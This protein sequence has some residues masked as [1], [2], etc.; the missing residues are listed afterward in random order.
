MRRLQI[1]LRCVVVA[2]FVAGVATTAGSTPTM[3]AANT[4][5]GAPTSLT[6]NGR[7]APLG[8]GT[9][10]LSFGWFV[11]D[12]DRGEVQKAYQVLVGIRPDVAADA[13]PV[14]DS[15]TVSSDES[16]AVN[17]TGPAL[18]SAT[19]Y[20]WT[21]R[22]WD[23]DGVASTY[24]SPQPFETGLLS[25]SDW[26]AGWIQGANGN[27]Y[28]S[29]FDLTKPIA[30]ARL[31]AT[32]QGMYRTRINGAEVPGN[33]LEPMWTTWD[34]R[35][36]V[37]T[38][39]V[40]SM[41]VEGRNAIGMTLVSGH[42]GTTGYQDLPP[43]ARAQLI[44]T[45]SDGGTATIGT[46]PSWRTAAGP[47]VAYINS[48][49]GENYTQTLEKSGWDRV[50]FNDASWGAVTAP[51]SP[52]SATL[53]PTVAPPARV[54]ATLPGQSVTAVPDSRTPGAT[55]YVVDFGRNI[56][57]WTRLT[58]S[59][60]AG[61][62]MQIIYGEH[63]SSTGEVVNYRPQTDTFRFSQTGAITHTTQF[64]V[65][66]FR[67]AE[68]RGTVR[69]VP[70]A[71]TLVAEVVHDDVRSA[72]EFVSSDPMFTAIDDAQRRTRLN[73]LHSVPEDNPNRE[74]RG[75]GADATVTADAALYDFDAGDMAALY[76]KFMADIRTGQSAT[77][78]VRDFNPYTDTGG[79]S[80][81]VAWGATLPMITW[82][83]YQYTGNRRIV[84]DNY[85]ATKAWIGFV[86]SILSNRGLI[87]ATSRSG[88]GAY[89]DWLPA[90]TSVPLPLLYTG[91][92]VEALRNAAS[93]AT[94]LGYGADATAFTNAVKPLVDAIQ[95]AYLNPTTHT[96][97]TGQV[98]NAVALEMG[99][100]PPQYLDI[101]FAAIVTDV[102]ARGGH[103]DGGIIGLQQ[104][105]RVLSEH[106]RADLVAGYLDKTDK[107]SFGFM[108]AHGPGTIWEWWG[109]LDSSNVN[110]LNQPAYGGAPGEWFYGYAAGIQPQPG[111]GQGGYH[112]IIFAPQ[113]EGTGSSA[114]AT[115]QTVRGPVSS[116][117]TRS[118]DN[119]TYSV[120]VP[121]NSHATVAIPRPGGEQVTIRESGAL[122][123]ESGV[124]NA[125]QPGLAYL[126]TDPGSVRY[127]VGS[128]TYVFTVGR[129]TT[130]RALGRPV[131]VRSATGYGTWAPAALTDGI[132]TST[133]SLGGYHSTDRNSN[134]LQQEWAVLDLGSSQPVGAVT[135][136]PANGGFGFPVR[137]VIQ[138]SD[139]PS[140]D[141][142]TILTDRSATDYPNPGAT[143][144]RF[145]GTASGRY[146]RIL[147]SKLARLYGTT[148]SMALAEMS[149]S[150]AT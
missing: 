86:R 98:A 19:R 144:Q 12:T 17:Y 93:M 115:V 137:F 37:R 133:T 123:Y 43:R 36:L 13:N 85:A 97:G 107:P 113:I 116:E 95:A 141:V 99:I 63:L 46:G 21:V 84:A 29:E 80:D 70:T 142:V 134:P 140:F 58:T 52:V 128:G 72:G 108:L 23:K 119:L 89:G 7:V 77:G 65:K 150:A 138:V 59:V 9:A 2:S 27:L 79:Y 57:G 22:T 60:Q 34:K 76:E 41:L 104:V 136:Y 62:I 3:A 132:A 103:L 6:V 51:S 92:Y 126:S 4:A 53:E 30:S 44:V 96:F 145:T 87:E 83:T 50:G 14:W 127:S 25:A 54:I 28:R 71:P 129:A 42:Y 94:L 78:A 1:L 100:V 121:V 81:D 5:P 131:T 8:I 120:T 69:A 15:G 38:Y 105:M 35:V 147:V 32:A 31:Y 109:G 64:D 88:T 139:S 122:I 118:G 75:W 10:G 117:W 16:V 55:A 67:Y 73:T 39:D 33:L 125:P 111:A 146:V 148:Y 135:L 91:L 90:F 18:S 74:R 47:V 106:G 26:T 114:S 124:R 66:G 24:A 20:Y 40:T 110:S 102:V 101:A 130:D 45:Y 11:N 82:R 56:A 149:V 61:D 143:P 48:Y 112:D 49:V 68:I